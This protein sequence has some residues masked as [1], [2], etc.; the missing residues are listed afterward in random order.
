MQAGLAAPAHV[1]VAAC[2]CKS[3]WWA[4]LVP[5]T[6]NARPFQQ[7]FAMTSLSV[8]HALTYIGDSA[9][10]LPCAA[11]LFAWLIAAPATRRIGW[12]WLVAVL[13]MSGGVVLSKTLYMVSGWHPAGWNFIGLSGHA[14]FSFLFWPSAGALVSGRSR[15]ARAAMIALGA[16]FALAISVASWVLRDHSMVEL[17]LGGLWGALISTVFLART[18]R[19]MTCAPMPRKWM[20]ASAALWMVIAF[21]HTF[22]STRMMRWIASH[23]SGHAT[24]H[25]RSSLNL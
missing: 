17:V 5:G 6:A 15:T 20:I 3:G 24:V 8:W 10:L 18:W 16:C 9:V 13:L 12:A 14:A 22:P 23:A 1:R 25:T 21:G 4:D 7:G 19:Q 11:L 2:A